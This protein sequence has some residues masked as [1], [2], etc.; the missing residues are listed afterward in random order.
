MKS[1]VVLIL[2]FI[3][4]LVLIFGTVYVT[5]F[6]DYSNWIW[7]ITVVVVLGFNIKWRE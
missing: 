4:Y 7:V 6:W 5:K 3:F 2:V 1:I